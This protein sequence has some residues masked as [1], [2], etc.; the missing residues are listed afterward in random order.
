MQPSRPRPA[1]PSRTYLPVLS[2]YFTPDQI[3][4]FQYLQSQTGTLISGST[5]LQFFDR[6]TYPESDLDIYA[7]HRHALPLVNWLSSIGYKFVA[8]NGQAEDVKQAFMETS[9]YVH[10]TET[11]PSRD[12]VPG[13]FSESVPV[14]RF[15]RGVA[16]V[17]NFEKRAKDGSKRKIQVITAVHSPK[18]IILHFHSTCVMN[19]ISH[20]KAYAL[21]PRATFSHRR[22]L[23]CSTAGSKQ[24]AARQKYR[25]RGWTLEKTTPLAEQY[26]TRSDFQLNCDHRRPGARSYRYVGD[27]Y[28]WVIPLARTQSTQT[29]QADRL[30]VNS[31]RLTYN[32]M[33]EAEMSFE[34]CGSSF[35]EYGYVVGSGLGEVKHTI[36]VVLQYVEARALTH[37]EE[38]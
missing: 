4:A 17:L 19:V 21:Y 8:Q 26:D 37:G 30:E 15:G 24:D 31:W 33:M 16:G 28:C 9:E 25:E 23:I 32:F 27:R 20:E 12:N 14:G 7:E 10:M 11:G 34:L 36:G 6:S 2:P 5:A 13:G 3:L 22:S 38:M 35:L 29:L 1:H 18:E